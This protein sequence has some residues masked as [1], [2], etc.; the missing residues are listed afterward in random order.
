MAGVTPYMAK[1][2]LD[3]CLGG[4]AATRPSSRLVGWATG[5]P[6]T[7]G[8]SAGP[9]TRVTFSPAAAS[10]PAGSG[11]VSNRAAMTSRATAIGTA[12]GW[13]MY[14]ATSGG[15][16]LFFGTV[17]AS[18]GCASSADLAAFAAGGLKITLS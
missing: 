7:N 18:L 8:D 16:R 4:A 17:T 11:S 3:W 5:S 6:N 15:N 1:Q 2:M 9:W 12:L 13:N 14:D 10:T